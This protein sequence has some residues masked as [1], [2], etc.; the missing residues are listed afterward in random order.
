MTDDQD[1][2]IEPQTFV[3]GI[4]VVDFGDARVARGLS[5]RPA[6]VCRHRSIVYDTA[7][8]RIY[9]EDCQR[10]LDPFDAFLVLVENMGEAQD[11][12]KRRAAEVKD[13]EAHAMIS[14]AAK[15]VDLI[16]RTRDQAPVCK[17]CG[18]GILPEDMLEGHRTTSR[19]W[20]QA[21][22]APYYAP[23]VQ[24][25][26]ARLNRSRGVGLDPKN[27]K[28]LLSFFV[29]ANAARGDHL[30]LTRALEILLARVKMTED[31]R[32]DVMSALIAARARANR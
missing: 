25:A 11:R 12:L 32:K 10:T 5:R 29:R 22:R 17:C 2:P 3:Y 13:A 28:A 6:R 15:A 14:R 16:W 7:E 26:L 30:T 27:R 23:E 18:H 4:N 1:P 24:E 31:M 9:C 20:E 21:R 8:R 19:K